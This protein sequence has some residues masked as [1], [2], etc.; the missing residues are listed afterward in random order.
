[1]ITNSK[2]YQLFTELL[3]QYTVLQIL[4]KVIPLEVKELHHS[5]LKLSRLYCRILERIHQQVEKDI[6]QLR[7]QITQLGGCII[8]EQ[9]ERTFRLVTTKFRGYLYQHRYTNDVLRGECE[10]LL[11]CYLT[12]ER[13]GER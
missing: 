10:K 9:Q 1:M 3:K 7:R 11:F 2:E 12:G 5:R 4:L 6:H 8:S 13:G